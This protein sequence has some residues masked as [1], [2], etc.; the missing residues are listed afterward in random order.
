MSHKILLLLLSLSIFQLAYGAGSPKKD[1]TVYYYSTVKF[2]ETPLSHFQGSIPLPKE[3]A[4]TRNHY[5]F[6]YDD[7]NKLRTIGFFNG[8]TPRN[9]NHTANLFTLAH[10][11]QFTYQDSTE[12][13]T[14]FNTQGRPITV[15]GDCYQFVYGLNALG[16]REALYFTNKLGEQIENSWQIYAYHWTYETDGSIIENRFN[17][18]GEPV[19]IR[20]GF[21]FYRLRLTFNSMGHIALLQNIDE[22]GNLVENT[23]GAAQ[24]QITTNAAGNFLQWRVLDK[25]GQLERG[26]GPDVAIGIQTFNEY[27]YE[28]GLEQR[29]EN[30]QAIFNHYGICKSETEFDEWGNMK[31]RRFYDT[32]GAPTLHKNAGYFQLKLDWDVSG[33]YRDKLSYYDVDGK[34]I[35]HQQRGYHRVSY[36]YDRNHNLIRISYHN[37]AGQLVN[38]TDNGTAYIRYEYDGNGE[39]WLSRRYTRNDQL[40]GG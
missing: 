23:S 35:E 28:I 25:A 3:M 31:A 7:Q 39:V 20:P 18:A 38:R 30:N 5:R 36:Q 27:G 6:T 14:F 13:I 15:L 4:L 11:L 1:S 32:S 9:P 34:P 8:D 33:N 2:V 24:D 16:F 22:A 19:S 40:I 26:N 10:R 17:R 21:E 37:I 29:D 12:T